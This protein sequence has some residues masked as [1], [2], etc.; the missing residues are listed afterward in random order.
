MPVGPAGAPLAEEEKVMPLDTAPMP[1]APS[2]EEEKA[3]PPETAPVV[4]AGTISSAAQAYGLP[5]DPVQP[6]VVAPGVPVAAVA[7]PS[8][9]TSPTSPFATSVIVVVAPFGEIE[10]VFATVAASSTHEPV[11]VVV[12]LPVQLVGV[13]VDEAVFDAPTVADAPSST[14]GKI[15]HRACAL[16]PLVAV[17]VTDPGAL[18]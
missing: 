6:R 7:F 5:G 4:V 2:T 17:R 12:M 10:G 18:L 16:L 9:L 3:I 8:R 1:A 14:Y 13:P 11:T 15:D